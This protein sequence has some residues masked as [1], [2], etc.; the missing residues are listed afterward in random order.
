MPTI[1]LTQRAVE[2]LKAPASGRIEYFDRVLPGFGLRIAAG[3]RKTWFVMYRVGGKK[4]R[5]TIGTLAVV[6]KVEKA[7][8]LAR[9]SLRQAQAGLH[10][11][12]QR[13]AA[14][15]KAAEK[16]DSFRA[17]AELYIE[18]YASKNT[19]LA[20]WRELQRQLELDVYP[21]WADRPIC[22]I[23]RHDVAELLDGI[24][25][26]GAPIQANRTLAR[27]RTLFNWAVDREIIA[28][29]PVTRMKRPIVERERSHTL[30]DDEIRL[31][32]LGC[33]RLG[34]PFG[35]MCKLLLLTAQRRTEVA[36]MYWSEIDLDKRTWTIPRERAKNDREHA[37]HLSELA[38]EVIE[39]LPQFSNGGGKGTQPDLVFTTTGKTHVSGYSKAKDRLDRH[40][41]DIMRSELADAGK[42]AAKAAIGEW[43]FHDLRRTAATGMAKLNAAPHVV[44]R[45]L[46]HVSGTIR[47]VAAVY[48]RHAYIEERKAALD[49]WGR[50]VESL[51]R[52]TPDNVV[53][54]VAKHV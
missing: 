2:T 27:L 34:W 35:P 17:V 25:D 47:G 18:R 49:T 12:E 19:K 7:R 4:V 29:N 20:T 23:T 6:A 53:Q 44:D 21:K 51:V 42:D 3:G 24:A 5:E 38:S 11:V 48:N 9:D 22:E 16:P 40:M 52:P 1:A 46:N 39:A 30:T 32:W 33:D 36:G 14:K 43:I 50:Y 41:L 31:F 45:I 37:V 8:D 15:R 13:R 10:P 26:R 54:L 28:V